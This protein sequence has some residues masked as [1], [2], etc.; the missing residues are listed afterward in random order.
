MDGEVVLICRI[1]AISVENESGGISV[2]T[3]AG[4]GAGR[5]NHAAS[6]DGIEC[7]GRCLMPRMR[8]WRES[9]W[10]GKYCIPFRLESI[11]G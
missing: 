5:E 8:P 10:R 11:E 1:A 6:A 7:E 3:S 2:E 4:I 9:T